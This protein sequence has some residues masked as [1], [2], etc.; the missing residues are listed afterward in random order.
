MYDSI[1]KML[2]IG[3]TRYRVYGKSVHY[4]PKCSIELYYKISF[5]LKT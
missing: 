5:I 2:V 4:L 1:E 3:R